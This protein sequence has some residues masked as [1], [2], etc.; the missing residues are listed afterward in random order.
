MRRLSPLVLASFLLLGPLSCERCGG[1]KTPPPPVDAGAGDAGAGEEP[2]GAALQVPEG[3]LLAGP[4]TYGVIAGVLVFSE[5]GVAGWPAKERKDRE[6]HELLLARG[7]PA[8]N[9]ELLLDEAVT[10]ESVLAAIGR[11]ARAAPAGSTFFFYY[12]GH[13]ARDEAGATHFLAHDSK[14]ADLAGTAIGVDAIESSLREAFAGERVVLMAD[15]CHSGALAPVAAALAREKQVQAAA[16][17]SAEASNLSTSNWTFTQAVIDGLR[18]DALGDAD[19]DGLLQLD[20]LGASVAA[21]MKHREGQRH[22]FASYGLPGRAPLAHAGEG[23]GAAVGPFPAG[24]YLRAPVGAG[25]RVVRVREPGAVESLVR[26]FDYSAFEDRRVKNA[27]LEA[28]AYERHPVG[29][30]LRVF[31]GGELWDAEVRAVEGDFHRIT[32]PGWDASW[33]EWIL[34]DRIAGLRPPPGEAAPGPALVEVEWGGSWWPALILEEKGKQLRI[35]YVGYDSSWDEWIP[36]ERLRRVKAGKEPA[37]V[38]E[39]VQVEWR[40]QWWPASILDRT[41]ERYLIR[42]DGY[43]TEWDEW[44]GEARIRRRG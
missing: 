23:P 14:S 1:A 17:T 43:G 2:A 3:A 13:G 22:G 29:A 16:L 7:V 6:L 34:S 20:E 18:G 35:H 11:V 10:R 33:D 9:L 28:I 5:P 24:A 42:Y 40:G 44:V 26:F 15:C 37:A 21:E 38:G 8:S 19:R 30:K 31:W 36:P 27:E 12:A 32:Y 41:G 39:P 4:R 25:H